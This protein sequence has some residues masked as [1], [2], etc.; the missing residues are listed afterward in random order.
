MDQHLERLLDRGLQLEYGAPPTSTE[1]VVIDVSGATPTVTISSGNQS[2]IFITAS[3]PLSITGGSLTVAAYSTISGG[4]SMTG[5][6]LEANGAAASLTVTG[7]TTVSV[8]S[9]YAEGGATLSLADLMSYQQPD[10]AYPVLQASGAGSVLSLPNVASISVPNDT[11]GMYVEA[12]AGGDVEIP[13]TTQITGNIVLEANSATSILDVSGLTTFTGGTLDYSGGTLNSSGATVNLP[14]LT[15]INQ[16]TF[17][18]SGG[19]T[20]SASARDRHAASSFEVTGGSKLNLDDLSSYQQPYN[21]YPVLQASGAGSVYRCPTSL[22]SACL[23]TGGIY[24]EASQAATSRSLWQL[25]SRETSSSQP[26][27]P[28]ASSM[29]RD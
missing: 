2:V 5:G 11:G 20:L 22:R 15:D 16:T 18:V 14:A 28:P 1:A 19:A 10:N 21:A 23:M 12:L 4:F 8:A 9:L 3:D 29:S 26:T 24:V 7:T 6:S 25:R 13:L 17:N 27:A